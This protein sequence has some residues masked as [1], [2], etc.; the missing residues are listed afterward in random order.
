MNAR[1]IVEVTLYDAPLINLFKSNEEKCGDVSFCATVTTQS[2]FPESWDSNPD[3]NF[4][5]IEVAPP[6]ASF[7]FIYLLY[8]RKIA[9]KAVFRPNRSSSS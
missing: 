6:S 3:P 5:R 7:D 4:Y 1:F 2:S 9:R 8:V